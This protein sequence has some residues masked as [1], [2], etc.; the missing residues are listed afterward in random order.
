MPI[1]DPP[2]HSVF[3]FPVPVLYLISRFGSFSICLFYPASVFK[4]LA[5]EFTSPKNL[6]SSVLYHNLFSEVFLHHVLRINSSVFLYFVLQMAILPFI[7]P[8]IFLYFPSVFLLRSRLLCL[9]TTFSP[10][11]S[12]ANWVNTN[13]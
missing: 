6:R 12:V 9:S 7:S 8:P 11:L 1:S 13:K 2:F 4:C 5:C 3:P 10:K